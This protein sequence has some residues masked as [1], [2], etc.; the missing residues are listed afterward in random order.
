MSKKLKNRL[1]E[2][3]LITDPTPPTTQN[4]KNDVDEITLRNPKYLE[5]LAMVGPF[6]FSSGQSFWVFIHF[7]S[8]PFALKFAD[9]CSD[10]LI[11]MRHLQ[12]IL[13]SR[14]YCWEE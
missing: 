2:K 6:L 12:L 5:I 14:N 9:F 8:P 13:C 4:R 1:N 11:G 7:F 3:K 10:K